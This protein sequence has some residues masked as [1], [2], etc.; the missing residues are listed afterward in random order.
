MK[1]GL[2]DA[3]RDLQELG[4]VE[5]SGRVFSAW[6][7]S[8]PDGP[9]EWD[10]VSG[11]EVR[12]PYTNAAGLVAGVLGLKRAD[13]PDRDKSWLFF[14]FLRQ[15]KPEAYSRDYETAKTPDGR[16]TT[17][18]LGQ[19]S[20]ELVE[21]SLELATRELYKVKSLPVDPAT[22]PPLQSAA[23]IES[24]RRSV[25]GLNQT[26]QNATAKATKQPDDA[27]RPKSEI[28]PEEGCVIVDVSR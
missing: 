25:D 19:F 4:R 8:R 17:V 9:E 20:R 7:D 2:E 27:P 18:C 16:L 1:P 14:D 10:F 22:D 21:L 6:E 3:C 13:A 23:D 26:L 12:E 28:E 5:S 11:K 15:E 24:L